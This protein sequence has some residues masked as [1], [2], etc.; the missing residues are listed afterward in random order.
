M[1]RFAYITLLIALLSVSSGVVFAVERFPPPTFDSGHELPVT[2]TPEPRADV[3]EYLD[4]V[5]L[6]GTLSLVSYL[7]LKRRSRRGIFW[8]GVFS[9]IYFGFWRKGCVCSIGSIQNVTLALFDTRYVVPMTVVAFFILP[10]LFTLFFGRTF[11]AGVCPLGAIQDIVS[12]RPKKVPSWLENGLGLLPY[13]YLGGAVLFAATG[14]AFII[15]EYDPFIAFFRRSGS[16]NMF[17]LGGAFLLVGLFVERPYCRFFCPYGVLLNLVSRAS[18]WHVTITP[19]ECIQC[20][21]CADV[22]PLGVIQKPNTGEA[23]LPATVLSGRHEGMKRLAMYIVILPV[24]IVLSGWLGV[25]I[26]PFFSRVNTTVSLAERIW[27]EDAGKVEETIEASDAFRGTGR[28]T[29]E[30][31]DEALNLKKQFAFGGGAF[32]GFIG[33][34]I[35]IKLIFLSIRRKRVDYEINRGGCVSCGRCFAYCPVGKEIMDMELL[36]ALGERD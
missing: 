20:H 8:A 11:C 10:I 4:V 19:A 24:L 31:Y 26:S 6:L 16:L 14:S 36:R 33:L 17:I 28:P 9:L 13:L 22:C 5:V 2:T 3:Y 18:K 25:R 12:V 7:A 30:L 29:E 34:V 15:C 27:L 35:G 1:M 21:L 32:G 23:T